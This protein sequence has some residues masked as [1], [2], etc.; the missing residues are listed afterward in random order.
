MINLLENASE[1]IAPKD[2]II[3]LE[4][5]LKDDDWVQELIKK[6]EKAIGW[7]DIVSITNSSFSFG[8]HV[9]KYAP[10]NLSIL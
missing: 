3:K 7:K 1:I 10:L 8:E 6:Q 4:Q 2:A 9:T 5:K